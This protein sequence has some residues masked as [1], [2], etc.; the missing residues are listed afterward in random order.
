MTS[1]SGKVR[2]RAVLIVD[3]PLRDLDGLTLLAWTLAQQGVETYLTPMYDQMFVVEAVK[4]DVVVTNYIRSNNVDLIRQYRR[5]GSR[6]VVVDTEGAVGQTSTGLVDLMSRTG[7]SELADRYCVWG[8]VQYDGFLAAGLLDRKRLRAT[9][10]PRYDF[11]SPPWRDALN[12]PD[13]TPGYVL[14]NTNLAAIAPRFS[15]G[16]DDERTVLRNVGMPSDYIEARIRDERI[17]RDGLIELLSDLS[18]TFPETQ[19]VLRPHPFESADP[20]KSLTQ[21]PNFQVRQEGTSLEWLNSSRALIHLNCT[22]AI[23]AVMLGR[24]PLMP[25]WLDSPAL[26]INGAADVSRAARSPDEI[27]AMLRVI[28]DGASLDE[29]AALKYVREKVIRD[30]FFKIDGAACG[31]VTAA[32]LEA[33]DDSP[34]AETGPP[35]WRSRVLTAVRRALGRKAWMGIKAWRDP[36]VR[37]RYSAKALDVGAVSALLSRISAASDGAAVGCESASTPAGAAGSLRIYPIAG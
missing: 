8:N 23:E 3:N 15:R 11:A 32:V 9:G 35:S 33:L 17:A 34:T 28:L 13:I 30:A 25:M 14:I 1:A 27:K 7:G 31:R 6:I 21:A 2:A 16:A 36:A 10:S 4:P 24:E 18:E 20:Y 29:E 19:F 37:T 5:A 26:H 22:T 12:I